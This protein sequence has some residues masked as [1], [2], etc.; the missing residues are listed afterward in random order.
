MGSPWG[1]TRTQAHIAKFH[2]S[3]GLIDEK[4]ME[5]MLEVEK[6]M[7]DGYKKKDPAAYDVCT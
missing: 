4:G 5:E 6:K 3:M 2:H 1:S 7:A